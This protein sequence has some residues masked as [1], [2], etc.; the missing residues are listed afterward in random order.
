MKILIE[1]PDKKYN[2]II[3]KMY[4]GI[5]DK[6]IYNAIENGTPLKDNTELQTQIIK[7]GS[8]NNGN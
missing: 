7:E 1:I 5:Y 3:N 2:C 4:C 8:Q 6:D